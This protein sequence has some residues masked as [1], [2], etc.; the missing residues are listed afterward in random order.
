MLGE[1]AKGCFSKIANLL[2]TAGQHF[3]IARRV[4]FKA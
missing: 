1:L 2:K 4:D 3:S